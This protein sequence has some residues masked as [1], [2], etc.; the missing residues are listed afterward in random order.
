MGHASGSSRS[1]ATST[2][3]ILL[4]GPPKSSRPTRFRPLGGP[5]RASRKHLSRMTPGEDGAAQ[6]RPRQLARSGTCSSREDRSAGNPDG[7]AARSDRTGARSRN[8]WRPTR[9]ATR[10]G[11]RPCLVGWF[12]TSRRHQECH[13]GRVAEDWTG[14]LAEADHR[15]GQVGSRFQPGVDHIRPKGITCSTMGVVVANT[16]FL[17][18]APDRTGRRP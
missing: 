10:C 9:A 17:A 3:A 12:I 16:R 5:A 14:I 6:A 11:R 4:G 7:E 2:A 18:Q 13:R 8:W 15:S 1:H